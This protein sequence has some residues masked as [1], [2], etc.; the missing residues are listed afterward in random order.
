MNS[1]A[2]AA[3]DVLGL[4]K[5]NGKSCLKFKSSIELF[6]NMYRRFKSVQVEDLCNS[7]R[8][9]ALDFFTNIIVERLQKYSTK[10]KESLNDTVR[11][12]LLLADTALEGTSGGGKN[13]TRKKR[14]TKKRLK[15]KRI[16]KKKNKTLR[17][18]KLTKKR[19]KKSKKHKTYKKM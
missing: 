8:S 5:I 13:M 17:P 10:D 15:R 3:D 19:N 1:D 11:D 9:D 18:I 2:Y 16:T 6:I 4:E 7:A 12:A 14:L